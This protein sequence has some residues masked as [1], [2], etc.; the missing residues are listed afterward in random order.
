MIGLIVDMYGRVLP[1]W[2]LVAWVFSFFATVRLG[3]EPLRAF[4]LS[5][6][7]QYRLKSVIPNI[8]SG[9]AMMSHLRMSQE[10]TGGETIIDGWALNLEFLSSR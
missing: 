9:S 1:A 5:H 10:E 7:I 4:F 8:K 6:Y 2:S 3:L